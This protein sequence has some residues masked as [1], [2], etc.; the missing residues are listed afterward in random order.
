MLGF[1]L[2]EKLPCGSGAAIRYV[3]KP[4]AYTFLS[5]GA[6]GNIE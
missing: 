1:K 2:L 6:S 3:N 5:I 4:L